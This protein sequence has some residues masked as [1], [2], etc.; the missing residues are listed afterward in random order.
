MI[1]MSN[2]S[3]YDRFRQ[4]Q[5][6]RR[7]IARSNS[8]LLGSIK[9]FV[10]APFARLFT[11]ATNE[12]DDPNDVSGKRRIVPN[13]NVDNN[14]IVEDGPAPAKRM[15]VRS[16]EP[17]STQ[18]SSG[19]LDPPGSVFSVKHQE[20]SFDKSPS[21]SASISLPSTTLP[22][23][24]LYNAR[25]TIS[26]LRNTF[27]RTMSIDHIP[28]NQSRPLTR[29]VSMKSLSSIPNLTTK[30]GSRDSMPPLQTHSF[31]LRDSSTPQP[32][33]TLGRPADRD[34]S[35]PPPVTVLASNPVF[36]RG[37]SQAP[38]SK[39]QPIPTLGS[40]VD[41][42]R[43]LRSP[44]RQRSLL[45]GSAQPA[46]NPQAIAAERTFHELE[47]YKTPLVPTRIRSRMP[48]SFGAS[49]SST[50]ITDMF[51]RKHSLV[52]MGDHD[53]PTKRD[54]KNKGKRKSKSKE[55]NDTKPYAGT[56]GIKKRLAKAKVPSQ[57]EDR[58]SVI[59]DEEK[60]VTVA[61]EI[62]VPPP[63]EKDTFSVVTYSSATSPAQ[64]SSLRV[65]RAARS[66]LSRPIKKF[67][68]SFDDEDDTVSDEA[69]KD[70]EML[71]EAAKKV[72]AFEIPA[73]FSFA[74][75]VSYIPSLCLAFR[76][77]IYRRCLL[78]NLLLTPRNL[79]S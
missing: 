61:P 42:Q 32:H 25:S 76:L 12:F 54:K 33:Y 15:R 36:V 19:Y 62:P 58:A 65:G 16:P 8:S 35:E 22:D 63:K 49:T 66:H 46:A 14:D 27:S 64:Q 24:S 17:H 9:N 67:S 59:E 77:I 57:D 52:L 41:S 28:S 47:F 26:P 6:Q 21:R 56:T 78:S 71:T 48:S 3:S 2:A 68:A 23:S 55:T 72:P 43:I 70:M 38:E 34:V 45:F 13:Q 69:K 1:P 39:T 51:A 40:L 4:A 30:T 73:G 53:R 5:A 31:R 44:S 20:T 37:P 79:R 50:N 29:D 60:E 10:A 7:S 11:G 18:R 75:D 74:K